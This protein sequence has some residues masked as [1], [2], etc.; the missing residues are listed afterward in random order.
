MVL[1]ASQAALFVSGKD[2]SSPRTRQTT[3]AATLPS[4]S[5]ALQRPDDRRIY[6]TMPANMITY[7]FFFEGLISEFGNKLPEPFFFPG[8][9]FLILVIITDRYF[10]Q[11]EPYSSQVKNA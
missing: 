2:T 8:G 3:R 6:H 11:G 7:R 9:L 4:W 5:S 1:L 10:L